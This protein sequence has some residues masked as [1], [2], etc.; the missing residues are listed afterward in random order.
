MII[1]KYVNNIGCRTRWHIYPLCH[2]IGSKR[3]VSPVVT[4]YKSKYRCSPLCFHLHVTEQA[5]FLMT[6]LQRKLCHSLPG[7]SLWLPLQELLR[8]CRIITFYH[9]SQPWQQPTFFHRSLW[10]CFGFTFSENLC[11]RWKRTPCCTS[12]WAVWQTSAL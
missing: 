3:S 9:R 4:A 7:S 10:R 8:Y 2:S 6:E 5:I 11:P 1:L 12:R